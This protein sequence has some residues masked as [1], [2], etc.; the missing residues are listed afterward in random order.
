VPYPYPVVAE[1]QTSYLAQAERRY[2]GKLEKLAQEGA[3]VTN[4]LRPRGHLSD[5][6]RI[7]TNGN[8]CI[9]CHRVGDFDPAGIDRVKAPD[10]SVVY[11]RLRPDY[12]RT[13]IAKPTAI[14][15]YSSMPINIP[16]DSAA[17]QL[18]STLS[19]D[20]YP[21]DS[22]EQMQALVDLLM[23]YD[24]YAREQS[25]VAPLVAPSGAAPQ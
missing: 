19:Q 25:R 8:Y 21:G 16:Y 5:A 15:P 6:M 1:R 2:A 17:P 22:L 23:N 3:L 14:L 4:A 10:L 7:V 18:G 12:L 20:L 9:K 24:Q 11:R 13:W